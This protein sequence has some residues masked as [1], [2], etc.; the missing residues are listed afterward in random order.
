MEL[1]RRH[2]EQGLSVDSAYD[3]LHQIWLEHGFQATEAATWQ[4]ALEAVMEKVWY[5]HPVV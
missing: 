3:V 2:R 5:G 4:E 1:V